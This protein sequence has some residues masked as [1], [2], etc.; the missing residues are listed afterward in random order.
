MAIITWKPSYSVGIRL[1]DA[2]HKKLF[3]I[4]NE[5]QAGVAESDLSKLEGIIFELKAYV[6]FHFGEEEKY[7][8]KFK[9]QGAASHIEQHQLYT[10]KINDL[11]AKLLKGETGVA[12]E[13]VDFLSGWIL[14]HVNIVDKQY[15]ACFRENGLV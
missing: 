10:E 6:Q 12:A 1:V 2:Q 4:L 15:T 14:N 9:Y 11:H 8:N 13:A 5:L 7:F 3:S